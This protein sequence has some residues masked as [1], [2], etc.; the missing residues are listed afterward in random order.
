MGMAMTGGDAGMAAMPGMKAQPAEP[1]GA[2]VPGM[3]MPGDA[4][5]AGTGAMHGPDK[6]GPGN[7]VVAMAPTNRLGEPGTVAT[8]EV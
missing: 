4:P 1:A 6:H 8:A 5:M 2:A 7:S 3:K